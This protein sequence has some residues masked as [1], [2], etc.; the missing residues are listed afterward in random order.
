MAKSGKPGAFRISEPDPNWVPLS[1]GPFVFRCFD[2]GG[3]G[4][5]EPTSFGTFEQHLIHAGATDALIDADAGKIR[6]EGDDWGFY[7]HPQLFNDHVDETGMDVPTS[8]RKA[9][10]TVWER[11]REE[12]MDALY[13]G[14]GT[15]V[16]KIGTPLSDTFE[17]VPNNSLDYF[18]VNDWRTN[19]GQ[20]GNNE[21][22]LV[23]VIDPSTEGADLIDEQDHS[24]PRLADAI[25]LIGRLYGE[26]LPSRRAV[27]QTSFFHA[28]VVYAE[29]NGPPKAPSRDTVLRARKLLSDQ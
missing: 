3:S 12:F 15:L 26:N 14:L 10:D 23:H 1:K 21:L 4:T 6:L 28:V 7:D 25:E 29:K 11:M 22:F 16:A 20:L 2:T 24:S 19:L 18:C 17:S 8:V 5:A 9:F 13:A 27:S